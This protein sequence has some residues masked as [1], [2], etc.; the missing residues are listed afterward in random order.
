MRR[1]HL[2]EKPGIRRRKALENQGQAAEELSKN[3]GENLW[4]TPTNS[5]PRFNV[6]V[7]VI[8]VQISAIVSGA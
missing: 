5:H 2:K 3:F 4:K 1:V 6:T 7:S 8:P